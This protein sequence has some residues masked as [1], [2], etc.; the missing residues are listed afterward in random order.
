MGVDCPTYRDFDKMLSVTNSDYVIVTTVDSTHDTFIVKALEHGCDVIT[1]KPITTDE[2]KAS[3]ILEAERKS[4]N[5]IIVALNYRWGSL[6]WRIKELIKNNTIGEVKTVDF[7]WYLGVGHG[8]SYFRRWH[9]YID[10]SGSLLVHKSTHHFDLLNWWLNSDPEE[11]FAYGGVDIYGKNGK[12]RG[13][14]CRSCDY[15][16]ECKFYWDIEKQEFYSKLYAKNEEYDGYF[17]D[18]CVYREDIDTYDNMVVQILYKNGIKVNYSLNAFLPYEGHWVAFNGTAGRIENEGDIPFDACSNE[19]T[20]DDDRY[21][22]EM[23]HE[24]TDLPEGKSA[25]H[26]TY[27]FKPMEHIEFDAAKTGHWG[28]DVPLLKEIFDHKSTD[29][30][31][32]KLADS[33]AGV[34][35]VLIGM[36]ARRSI[37][38]GEV[39]KISSLTDISLSDRIM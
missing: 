25:I 15:K 20:I 10:K 17:R 19:Q 23:T 3:R 5:K 6:F 13:K 27:Q 18:G 1:E 38:T 8:S 11:V 4:S 30:P 24:D 35:A 36:A 26:I 29:D 39:V 31:L 7:S 16:K 2:T 14:N 21:E 33:R 28:G 32:N 12:F 22:K 9:G 34:M 37:E